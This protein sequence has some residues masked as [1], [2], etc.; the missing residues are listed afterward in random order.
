MHDRLCFATTSRREPG[1]DYSD[2]RYRHLHR[3]PVARGAH[4]FGAVAGKAVGL[5]VSGLAGAVAYDGVKKVARSGAVREAAVSM[6]TWGLKGARAAETG[7]EKARLATADIRDER[8]REHRHR[9]PGRHRPQRRR[10][11]HPLRRPG[12]ARADRAGRGRRGRAGPRRRCAAGAR[13]PAHRQRRRLVPPGLRP[14]RAR[15]GHRQGPRRRTGGHRGPYPSLGRPAQRGAGPAGRRRGRAGR[16]GLPPLRPAPPAGARADQPHRRHRR[17]DLHR[18]PVPARRAALA[19]RRARRGDRRAGLRRHRRQP[20]AARERRRADRAVAAQHRRVPAGPHAAPLPARDL[21]AAHRRPDPHLDAPGRRHRDRGRHRR[22]RARRRGRRARARRAAGRR[23][24]RRG[25]RR[26]RPGRDHRRAAAGHRRPRHPARRVGAAARADRRPG[27]RRRPRHRDR[28]DHRPGRAGP[29]R[30]RPDPDRRRELLPPVRAGLVRALGADP[31]RHPRRA[32]RDDDAAR[33]LPVRG[34]PVH[35]D[36]DQRGDRQRRAARHP[37]QGRRA[38]RGGRPGRR[39]GVRQDRHAHPGPPGRHER[40]LLR[41]RLVARAG[42]GL[43]RVVGDPLPA[44]AGPGRHPLHRGAAD[45]DPAARG[46]RGAAR[47]GHAGPGRRPGTAHRLTR[48]APR[49]GRHG[50]AQGRGLGAAA[51]EGLGDPPAARRRR[52]AGR[53][54]LAARHRAVGVPRGARRAARRRRHPDRHA[55]RRPPPDRE[56]RRRGARH[57]RVPRRGHARGQAGR[58]AGTAGRG[59]HRRDG[60]RRHQ[61]R[62]RARAGRHRHRDGRRRDRRGGGDRRRRPRRRRPQR[63]ARPARPRAALDHPD[64]AELRHVDRGERGRAAG[65]RRRGD[66]TGGRGDPAQR[67][68]RR[69]RREQLPAD[70]L[71]DPR[72]RGDDRHPGADGQLPGRGRHRCGQ[73]D[74]GLGE[75]GQDGAEPQRDAEAHRGGEGGARPAGHDGGGHA[76]QGPR[77]GPT[78]PH[79]APPRGP[80]VNPT[81]APDRTNRVSRTRHSVPAY[82]LWTADTPAAHGP[83]R[84]C[85]TPPSTSSAPGA[86]RR[87][88][89]A[90]SPP[91]RGPRSPRRRT[92]SAPAGTAS[93]D[94]GPH[95]VDEQ[96]VHPP[97]PGQLGV[98][99]RGEHRALPDRDRPPCCL[100]RVDTVAGDI[101]DRGEHLD[102]TAGLLDP[103]RPDEHRVHRVAGETGELQVGLEGVDLPAEGVAPHDDVEPAELV[104]VGSSV[105]DLLG[106]QDHAGT[107]AVRGQAVAQPGAQRLQELERVEQLGHRGRLAAGQDDAVHHGQLGRTADRHGLGAR[108]GQRRHVLADVAL[109]G[110][111]TDPHRH[112]RQPRPVRPAVTARPGVSR[113]TVR[114]CRGPGCG[115]DPG[116]PRGAGPARPGHGGGASWTSERRCGSSGPNP[117]PCRATRSGDRRTRRPTGRRSRLRR[118]RT[119]RRGRSPTG[120]VNR[121]APRADHTVGRHRTGRRGR[122][123]RL[124]VLACR[125]PGHRAAAAFPGAR[126]H[127]VAARRGPRSP[128]RAARTRGT[129]PGLHLRRARGPRPGPGRRRGVRPR[130]RAGLRRAVGSRRRG[131]ARLAGR[132][133][134]T[135]R[136]VLRARAGR[137]GA[138]RAGADL[139]GRG[140]PAAAPGR[141]HRR[142]AAPGRDGGRGPGAAADGRGLDDAAAAFVT[143]VPVPDAPVQ[144]VRVPRARR[145]A[146]GRRRCSPCSPRPRPPPSSTSPVPAPVPAQPG[147]LG[148]GGRDGR[149]EHAR[150][151]ERRVRLGHHVGDRRRGGEHHLVGDVVRLRVE[152]PAEHA[153]EREHVVDLVR[154]VR[155]PGG[156]DGGVLLGHRRV[157]LGVRVG[158]CEHDRVVGHGPQLV[159]AEQ[160]RRADPDEDVGPDERVG[161]GALLA[162]LV[163]LR[164]DRDQVLVHAGTVRVDDAVDVDRDHV[165]G[166]L[167]PEQPDDRRA[168]RTDPADD[169]ADVG[170]LLADHAQ[171]VAQGAEDDDGGAVLVV[172][173]DRDVEQLAQPA[174]DLEAARRGDVLEVDA[175]VAGGDHLDG[176]DDLLGVLGV[177]ADRPGVDVGELLEQRRLA[178]HHRHRRGGADVAQAEHR[179]AVGDDGDG[180]ALDRQAP[181]VGRVLRDRHRHPRD[182]RGVGAGEIVTGTQVDLRPD[183]DLAAEVE[184]EGPVGDLADGEALELLDGGL[185]LLDAVT[186]PPTWPTAA[187]RSPAEVGW[188]GASTRAVMA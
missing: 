138:Q 20:G 118:S 157:D 4:V 79:G 31:A 54:G 66:V 167:R 178:L 45:R 141:G 158:Q 112:A 76:S 128:L 187:V 37:D 152:Q 95:H 108:R 184:Q 89:G 185:D 121:R 176:A 49:P 64:P 126:G 46:V 58:R 53:A 180:V 159:L 69:G 129:G 12:P 28:A 181:G 123:R 148:D 1:A 136:A 91:G 3:A 21:R 14:R 75:P 179:G 177:E 34:R 102:V 115:T 25:R 171:R 140:A 32:A 13:L 150:H 77:A 42:P 88:A 101:R 175:A 33:R 72:R 172:V 156:H 168:G 5:V 40:H 97:V 183:L 47:A 133:R 131:R 39:G 98:E 68:Q 165:R 137:P 173:E 151:D 86:S 18:L 161:Q 144:P 71:P 16:A 59:P 27:H 48:P 30:P 82:A 113:G 182:A 174:L 56:G 153:G 26:G 134:G 74:Q 67:L 85:S 7:A 23:R 29:G 87:R 57:H 103:R 41:R 92:T 169:D 132:R 160:V 2:N 84:P 104:L 146:S 44:P 38:P 50:P 19:D 24:G 125:G 139:P 100:T 94:G 55:H 36:G 143:A 122:R 78:G 22:R 119:A 111:H 63:A 11:P 15:R 114:R 109:Q 93:S 163:G 116:I 61:R 81:P 149:V 135:A 10:G 164:R 106:Q 6:T 52:P 70:P 51:A 170:E 155:A 80:G 17:H 99:R 130:H 162:V 127:R 62:P 110:Q 90:P 142:A 65:L 35:P 147:G 60:R 107:R 43:R 124:A 9:R 186:T 73:P 105:Q 145:F 8:D 117:W 96:P 188:A 166:L 154:V 120:P 83:G